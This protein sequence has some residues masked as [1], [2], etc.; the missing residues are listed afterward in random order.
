MDPWLVDGEYYGSWAHYPPFDWNDNYFSTIDF[1][2]IS[3]IHP[4]HLSPATMARLPKNIPVLLHRYEFPF[5]KRNI[6]ALGFEVRELSHNKPTNIGNN[7]IITILAADNCDPELCAKFMGCIATQTKLGSAQI[8]SLCVVS[9]GRH[10]LVN[11][12]DCPFGLSRT[13]LP[14]IKNAFGPIDFLL[15]GYSGAGPYP[16]CFSN[17]TTIERE[18]AAVAKK[19]QFL[20]DGVSYINAL[21]PHF[22]MPFAGQYMLAG[23]LA[24]LNNIRGVAELEEAGDYFARNTQSQ[25]VL[26]NSGENFDLNNKTVS[27]P[28]K[29][30]NIEARSAYV[31]NELSHRGYVFDSDSE[32]TDVD[33]EERL[34]PA[35]ERMTRYRVNNG[36]SSD[37]NVYLDVGNEYFA[38]L[39]MDGR[40]LSVVRS[41]DR[42]RPFVKISLDRKLLKRLL[43][44]PRFAHWNNAEIGSHLDFYRVPNVYQRA[45]YN[46][47]CFFHI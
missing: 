9:D 47:V 3:H 43:S 4:D 33:I 29:P 44:G 16:Q 27:L 37:Q 22:V 20:N 7:V 35:F 45:V 36:I 46:A 11:A 15:T 19:F 5:L 23:R 6:E 21:S 28:Y 1:I 42:D 39:P 2:Y 14:G 18:K 32:P 25:I 24:R 13:M 17:L 8:D 41:M 26:L 38:M 34:A 40:A 31:Q 12:N 10:V 30:T